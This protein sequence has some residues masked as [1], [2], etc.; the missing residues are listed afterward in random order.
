MGPYTRPRI[1]GF[2]WDEVIPISGVTWDPIYI[3]THF[4][5]ILC[6]FELHP[7]SN[8][9]QV[10]VIGD[11]L[12]KKNVGV[13]GPIFETFGNPFANHLLTSWDIQVHPRKFS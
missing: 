9:I 11:G 5:A 8:R 7:W 2:H 4:V 1:N 6:L 3:K 10:Q 13:T 12:A